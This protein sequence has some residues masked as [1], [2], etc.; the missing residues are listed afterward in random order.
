MVGNGELALL[1]DDVQDCL[2]MVDILRNQWLA[3]VGHS[4]S[5]FNGGENCF[6]A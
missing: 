2:R 6:D 5:G 3:V 1:Y 4:H